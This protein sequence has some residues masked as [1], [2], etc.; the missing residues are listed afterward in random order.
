MDDLAEPSGEYEEAASVEIHAPMHA[1]VL[2][3]VGPG[4]HLVSEGARVGGGVNNLAIVKILAVKA[5]TTTIRSSQKQERL[6]KEAAAVA[7]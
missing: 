2:V 1:T 7:R 4:V 3:C 5:A 6:R